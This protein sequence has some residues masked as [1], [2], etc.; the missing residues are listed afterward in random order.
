[1]INK[2]HFFCTPIWTEH[3]EEFVNSL[4]KYSEPHIKKARKRNEKAI[5]DLKDFGLVHHSESLLAD[6]N[7]LDF[8]TYIGE[9][10]FDFLIDQEFDMEKYRL[11]FS[12][13][14]V[15]EF[16]KNGGGHH[17]THIHSNQHVSGFY[18]LKCSLKTSYPVFYD[19]RSGARATKLKSIKKSFSADETIFFN[20]VPG[21]LVIFPGYLEH[22]FVI[23]FGKDLFRFIH[24][25]LQAIPKEMAIE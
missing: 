21:S 22:E 25:N 12:E 17:S 7:F 15:Q 2:L 16:S 9:K 18:F 11:A 5:K 8:K 3:K 4:N 24:F 20:P 6:N 14:W 1:M 19:P 10:C 13:M 23:D